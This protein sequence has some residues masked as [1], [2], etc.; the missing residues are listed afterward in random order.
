MQARVT[1]CPA[2][3]WSLNLRR[4]GQRGLDHHRHRLPR[5][6][7]PA[8]LPARLPGRLRPGRRQGAEGAALARFF[9]WA[10]A[11]ADLAAWHR[12]AGPGARTGMA[13]TGTGGPLAGGGPAP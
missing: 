10:A 2:T 1:G 12:G 9:P 8:G 5:R 11:A 6:V 4:A 13:D 7:Q 3:V